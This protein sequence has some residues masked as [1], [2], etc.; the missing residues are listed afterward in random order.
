MPRRHV[1]PVLALLLHLLPTLTR[2]WLPTFDNS[3]SALRGVNLGSLFIIENWMASTV[4]R[5]WSCNTASEFDCVSSLPSQ[6]DANAKWASHW[7]SWVTADDFKLMR[8]YGLNT[9]RIPVGYWFLENIVDGSEHFPQGGERYLDQVVGWA[10]DAGLYTIIVLHGAPGAQV[11]DAFTGQLNPDPGFY[12]DYNY[13][14]AAKW[15]EWMT[16]KIHTNDAYSM[17]GMLELVNEPE[18][19]WDT[20]KYPDAE[21]NAASMIEV[22]AS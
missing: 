15:L 4:M 17:V 7:N 12:D 1:S 2:A 8:E 9:V 20:Q 22:S 19:T 10:K 21:T 11:T 13:E 3:H 6:S 5:P 18:R 14:R 16:E